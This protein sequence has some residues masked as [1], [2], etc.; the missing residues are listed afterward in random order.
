MFRR[1]GAA[2]STELEVPVGE[3]NPLL[4]ASYLQI[5]REGLGWQKSQNGGPSVPQAGPQNSAYHRFGSHVAFGA[6]E[7]SGIKAA[8]NILASAYPNALSDFMGL[9]LVPSVPSMVV[10]LSAAVLT[11]AYQKFG[12]ERDFVF[13]VD[14]SF[15]VEGTDPLRG[16]FLLLPDMPSLRAIFD[17]IRL[18]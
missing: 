7:Q 13:C 8:G 10:D 4:G 3:Y 9:M 17:A 2:L 1:S 18:P 5:A 14:T 15:R 12:H 16:H 6:K 11:S